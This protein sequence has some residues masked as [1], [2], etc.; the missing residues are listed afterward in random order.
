[1]ERKDT[2]RTRSV[3]TIIQGLVATAI[4]A[5]ATFIVDVLDPELAG[6]LDYWKTAFPVLCGSV[7]MAVAAYLQKLYDDTK[8]VESALDN[9]YRT[10]PCDDPTCSYREM[11][12]HTHGEECGANCQTCKAY[13]EN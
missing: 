5:V 4:V 13:D 12:P 2:P 1:M 7:I 8:N 3:R 10:L 11:F 9:H 6:S